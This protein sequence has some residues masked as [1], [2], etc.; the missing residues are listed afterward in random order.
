MRRA[1]ATE[2]MKAMNRLKLAMLATLGAM[3]LG[4][5]GGGAGSEPVTAPPPV[6]GEPD[7]PTDP[8]E[9]GGPVDPGRPV[10]PPQP[11]SPPQPDAP[12]LRLLA[13]STGGSGSTDGAA[14]VTRFETPAGV[15]VDAEGNTFVADMTMHTIRRIAADGTSTTLAGSPGLTGAVDGNG[16]KARFNGPTALALDDQGG[17]FVADTFN[18]TIRHVSARGDVTTVAGTAGQIGDTGGPALQSTFNFPRSLVR[19]G[20][21]LF[22][23]DSGNHVVRTLQAGST[24]VVAGKSRTRGIATADT[25]PSEARFDQPVALALRESDK[26]LFVLDAGN[27]VLRSI[28]SDPASGDRV[29]I[30]VGANGECQSKDDPVPLRARLNTREAVLSQDHA[31]S[32]AIAGDGRL[33]FSEGPLNDGRLRIA[34]GTLGVV[35]LKHGANQADGPLSL[36]SFARPKGLGI[37]LDSSEVVVSDGSLIRAIDTDPA[38]RRVVTVSGQRDAVGGS[39]DSAD[40]RSARF[41]RP[42]GIALAADKKTLLVADRGSDLREV[43]PN[44]AVR[45]RRQEQQGAT[46]FMIAAGEA[47]T[48]LVFALL[49][50]GGGRA[51]LQTW[52]LTGD[53]AYRIAATGTPIDGTVGLAAFGCPTGLAVDTQD[54]AVV[55]DPCAHAVRRVTPGGAVSRVAGSYAAAGSAEGNALLEA[56]FEAPF[57]VAIGGDGSI[58]VLDAVNLTLSKITGAGASA[59]VKVVAA[60]FTDPRGVAVD[61]HDNVYVAEGTLDVVKRVEPGG[62]VSVIA[63]RPGQHGFVPGALPGALAFPA[64][65]ANNLDPQNKVGMSVRN[66]RLVMTMENGIVEIGPLPQ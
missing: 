57:D 50:F 8:V 51:D 66:N 1:S 19:D 34:E 14:A 48:G 26:A 15:V 21:R 12:Q 40:G 41:S 22:I 55:A 54:N 62:K 5:C 27:C 45:T 20:N 64:R 29:R 39:T 37:R 9:P 10:D 59:S 58:Y 24:A 13:G 16:A 60:G 25:T 36:A 49:D 28:T 42:L 56:R 44:G 46:A 32:M 38:A 35:T 63:G 52:S 65:Q 33:Y 11:P 3:V 23:A 47:R 4:A 61:S 18:H 53:A 7:T 31:M 30:V 17:V 6:G 2:E 43:D